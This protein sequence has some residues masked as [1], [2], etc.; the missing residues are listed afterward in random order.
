MRV[1]HVVAER[2]A[3]EHLVP[4]LEDEDPAIRKTATRRLSE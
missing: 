1:R 2:I 3:P 4:L